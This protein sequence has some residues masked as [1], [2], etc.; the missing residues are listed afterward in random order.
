MQAAGKDGIQTKF[1][2][3][4]EVKQFIL[5]H[6]DFCLDEQRKSDF[7]NVLTQETYSPAAKKLV[8]GIVSTIDE[9]S[10]IHI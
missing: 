4:D 2:S 6:K 10:L 9:L 5:T 1:Q 3:W 7:T 8:T